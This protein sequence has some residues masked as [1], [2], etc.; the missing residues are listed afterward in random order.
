M[1]HASRQKRN[2]VWYLINFLNCLSHPLPPE[3]QPP[4]LPAAFFAHDT[5]LPH[6]FGAGSSMEGDSEVQKLFHSRVVQDVPV[7]AHL[8]LSE[9]DLF[10]GTR[11]TP[12]IQACGD[13]TLT[14]RSVDTERL[15]NHLRREGKLTEICAHEVCYRVI[16]LL[17][18]EPNMLSLRAPLSCTNHRRIALVKTQAV[19]F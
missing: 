13:L 10:C 2:S 5:R 1:C 8:A 9:E 6:L 3:L 14:D 7:P 17:E 4:H 19:S 12:N 11:L 15:K 16:D 18:Q